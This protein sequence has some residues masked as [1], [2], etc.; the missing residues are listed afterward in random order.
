[1]MG[2][3]VPVFTSSNNTSGN[4]D[5]SVSVDYKDVG[6]KLEVVP[7]INDYAKG[8]VT[9]DIKPSIS[10]I[11]QWIKT[12]NNRAPQ[13]ST[14][15]ASTILR[16]KAGETIYLGGLLK[17][18]EIKNIKAIPFLSKLPILGELFKSRT[19]NKEKTEVIIAIT[20][21]IIK[22]VDGI[23]QIHE[24]KNNNRLEA[25]RR[26][27]LKDEL[28]DNDNTIPS[29]PD[30]SFV[31]NFEEINNEIE[32]QMALEKERETRTIPEHGPHKF[33]RMYEAYKRNAQSPHVALS[34]SVP[35]PKSNSFTTVPVSKNI[36]RPKN[37]TTPTTNAAILQEIVA[38]SQM[39]LKYLALLEKE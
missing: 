5:A 7:R 34:S 29:K 22:D 37:K 25:T 17:D 6:V 16:V 30:S 2:D 18:Q 35:I 14:R 3:K 12:D 15:E 28:S 9:M 19:I 10:T 38:T 21:E 26:M 32:S 33:R 27:A 36:E 13:I 24:Q 23:P 31:K 39:L 1:M 20:P 8:V 11:A 4:V